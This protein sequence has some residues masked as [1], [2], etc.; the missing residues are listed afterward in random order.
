MPY[1]SASEVMIR[2]EALYRAYVYL[3][4]YCITFETV[5]EETVD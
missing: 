4:I 1:L 3:Y 5:R 2:E